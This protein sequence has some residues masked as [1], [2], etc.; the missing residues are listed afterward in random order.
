MQHKL[1]RLR[2]YRNDMAD[3][4]RQVLADRA[5]TQLPKVKAA[6]D[7]KDSAAFEKESEAYLQLPR[8]L[9]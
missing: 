7:A 5:R 1:N 9:C 4:C 8:F 3:I 6:Y 2:T